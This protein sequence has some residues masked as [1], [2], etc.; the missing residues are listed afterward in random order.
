MYREVTMIEVRE[1]LRL[2]GE[3]PAEEADRRPARAR[4]EKRSAAVSRLRRL[5]ASVS[6][7]PSAMMKSAKSY[8]RSI[9]PVVGRVAT[10]GASASSIAP[11][12]APGQRIAAMEERE[13]AISATPPDDTPAPA[14]G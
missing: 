2:R 11:R 4:S 8:S 14:A 7:Q 10:D 5:L 3:G 1:V 12:L 13:K 6:R 9:P